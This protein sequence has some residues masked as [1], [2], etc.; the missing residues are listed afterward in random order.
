[1]S[2]HWCGPR[3]AASKPWFHWSQWKYKAVGKACRKREGLGVFRKLQVFWELFWKSLLAELLKITENWVEGHWQ[4]AILD[5]I[6]VPFLTVLVQSLVKYPETPRASAQQLQLHQPKALPGFVWISPA[7]TWAHYFCP[8]H[9]C[10]GEKCIFFLFFTSFKFF[11]SSPG[12]TYPPLLTFPRSSCSFGSLLTP[13]VVSSEL[14][15]ANSRP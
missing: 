5:A 12:R 8:T 9:S 15:A 6:P 10:N 13:A 3:A 7:V 2:S 11:L 14:P 1:M 4:D